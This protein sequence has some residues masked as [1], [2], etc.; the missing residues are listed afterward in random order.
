MTSSGPVWVHVIHW[1]WKDVTVHEYQL[2]HSPIYAIFSWIKMF[3]TNN[4][5]LSSLL[6]AA[7]DV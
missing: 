5:A 3:Q 1:K 4:D 6:N 7:A 2:T